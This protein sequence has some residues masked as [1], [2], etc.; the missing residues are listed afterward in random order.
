MPS[1]EDGASPPALVEAT[2]ELIA[3]ARFTLIEDTG[4]LPCVEAPDA[5]AGALTDFLKE[6]G[7]V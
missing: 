1:S 7:H 4:H 2:L 6:L 3:D 5:Y